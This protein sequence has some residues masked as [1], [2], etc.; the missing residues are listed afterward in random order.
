MPLSAIGK[1][2]VLILIYINF[3]E[4]MIRVLTDFEFYV[5]SEIGC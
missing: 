2:N 4:K 5:F 3:S 1:M